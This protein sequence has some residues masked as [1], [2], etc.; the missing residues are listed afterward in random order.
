MQIM[1]WCLKNPTH[2]SSPYQISSQG[3]IFVVWI[4]RKSFLY[5]R[6]NFIY[7]VQFVNKRYFRVWCV[8]IFF[9]I[10][11]LLILWQNW[12]AKIDVESLLLFF[13]MIVN[14]QFNQESKIYFFANLWPNFTSSLIFNFSSWCWWASEAI[15]WTYQSGLVSM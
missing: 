1:S 13:F 10:L 6:V 8:H 14:L 3:Q 2:F 12:W 7:S 5:Y 4:E 9:F 11:Q 15:F